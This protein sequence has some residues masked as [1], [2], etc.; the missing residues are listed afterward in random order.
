MSTRPTATCSRCRAAAPSG[1][2]ADQSGVDNLVL[3]GDWTRCGLDA[4][5]IEAAVMSGI[6][7]ANVV[8]GRRLTAGLAGRWHGLEPDLLEAAGARG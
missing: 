7:A 5:C 3:A 2:A 4:G 6:E 1:S 8:A